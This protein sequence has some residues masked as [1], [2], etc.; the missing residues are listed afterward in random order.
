MMRTKRN[1][2][3]RLDTAAALSDNGAGIAGV[4]GVGGRLDRSTKSVPATVIQ[5]T[6]PTEFSLSGGMKRC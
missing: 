2:N 6:S 5:L 4:D 1:K 3:G